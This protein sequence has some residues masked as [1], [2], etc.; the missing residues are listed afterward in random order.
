MVNSR[1][2]LDGS[3]VEQQLLDDKL[4]KTALYYMQIAHG[5]LMGRT[6][7]FVM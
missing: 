5:S 6:S 7:F 4:N 3:I 2:S 1:Q